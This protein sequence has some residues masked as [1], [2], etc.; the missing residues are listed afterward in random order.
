LAFVVHPGLARGPTIPVA[1]RLEYQRLTKPSHMRQ[2]ID[3]SGA[4]TRVLG[5]DACTCDAARR[6]LARV[7][8]ASERR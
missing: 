4:A 6:A 2:V 3:R 5:A 7:G 1:V 8:S